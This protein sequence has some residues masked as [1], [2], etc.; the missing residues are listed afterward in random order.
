MII[1]S[2]IISSADP[3][4][5]QGARTPLENYKNIGFL[6]T[7]VPDPYNNHKAT[8]PAFNEGASSARQRNAI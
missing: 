5:G 7:T 2:F 8:K 6:S 1:E 4:G 3:E